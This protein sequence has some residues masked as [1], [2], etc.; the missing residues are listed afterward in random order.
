MSTCT[1]TAK[2][3]DEIS[4]RKDAFPDHCVVLDIKLDPIGQL[5]GEQVVVADAPAGLG[6]LVPLAR[7]LATRINMDAVRQAGNAGMS[8][9]CRKGCAACCKYLVPLSAPEALCMGRE[10]GSLSGSCEAST[11]QA[12]TA[13]ADC[14]MEAWPEYSFPETDPDDDGG[15]ASAIESIGRWYAALDLDCP[16][17]SDGACTIYDKRLIACREYSML[18]AAGHCEG[19]NPGHG[20][21]LEMPLKVLEA[22]GQLA[23]EM[24]QTEVQAVMMP[25][26]PFWYAENRHRERRTW[27]G[28]E[29]VSR[30]LD[31]LARTASETVLDAAEAA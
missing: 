21:R 13:A 28:P 17:L 3:V 23:A 8:V 18:G 20:N 15:E 6:D 7:T 27:P 29:L 11:A 16:F 19:F 26:V 24:E 22:L 14:I 9:P 30:F 25:L 5:I 2:L 4:V 1:F 10:I 12:L 31:C